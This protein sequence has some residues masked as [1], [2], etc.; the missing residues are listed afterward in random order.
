MERFI[1]YWAIDGSGTDQEDSICIQYMKSDIKKRILVYDKDLCLSTSCNT[2]SRY[3]F[4]SC[5]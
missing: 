4:M 3:C 2:S 1:H 5:C